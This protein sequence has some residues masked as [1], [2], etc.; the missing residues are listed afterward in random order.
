MRSLRDEWE[1]AERRVAGPVAVCRS[2][3]DSTDKDNRS[4]AGVSA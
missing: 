1:A 2:R 3:R 4:G